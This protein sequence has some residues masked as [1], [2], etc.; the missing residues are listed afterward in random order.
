MEEL[1][2]RA[3]DGK[4]L[5]P[6]WAA[7][8]ILTSFIIMGLSYVKNTS[9]DESDKKLLAHEQTALVRFKKLEDDYN[10]RSLQLNDI[11]RRQ[12]FM[13]KALEEARQSAKDTN[14]TVNQIAA[15]LN[16]ENN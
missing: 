14:K 15:K 2:R 6:A 5:I 10:K 12:E 7:P 3:E 1:K 8:L 11:E 9:G 13:A 4:I 16:V